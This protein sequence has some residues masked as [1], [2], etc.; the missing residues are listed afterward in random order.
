[1]TFASLAVMVYF[2]R[3]RDLAGD[4]SVWHRFW[5]PLLSFAAL[6][7]ILYDTIATFNVLLGVGGH[8][9]V[10]WLLPGAFGVAAVL[11]VLVAVIIKAVN[12]AA[13]AGIGGMLR[14][15][16]YGADTGAA[17]AHARA[18]TPAPGGAR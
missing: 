16:D 5:A 15:G 3:H 11:G 12:P 2:W 13:F 6:A 4:A 17:P 8:D 1:M 9:V 10:R 7:L 18:E 14:T